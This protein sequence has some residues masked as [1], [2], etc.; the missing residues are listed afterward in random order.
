MQNVR[1]VRVVIKAVL[2]CAL[3]NLAFAYF[4]PPVGKLGIYNR[5]VVG[6][7]R[8]PNSPTE[9]DFPFVHSVSV[10]DN[11]D[12]LFASHVI[13]DG[14]KP[15][16]EYR[17]VFLGD[18]SVW[19]L[20]LPPR[21]TLTEQINRMHLTTCSGLHVRAYNLGF[22]VPSALR[23][24]LLIEKAQEYQPDMF[25]WLV[26]VNTFLDSSSSR[27]FLVANVGGVRTLVGR[28]HLDIDLSGI[29]PPSFWDNTFI[30]QRSALHKIALLQ[31]VGLAWAA[32]GVD[33]Y[34]TTSASAPI[35]P[36]NNSDYGQF[37]SPKFKDELLASLLLNVL[38]AGKEEAKGAA[39]LVVNE[40]IHVLPGSQNSVRYNAAFPRWAYDAYRQAWGGYVQDRGLRF[41]DLWDFL[42]DS[43]FFVN[44]SLHRS[45]AGE[46]MLADRL[47]PE[48]LQSACP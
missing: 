35:P 24:L 13:S 20:G 11:F 15:L 27:S 1:P 14:P 41:L 17:V 30:G 40:P 33:S 5:L 32:T 34:V 28:Y 12:A 26:T 36:L 16:D 42:A 31:L 47:A 29:R 18:S 39:L 21:A 22:P 46:Q 25:I 6:R 44:S 2:L 45:A 19:G 23:D 48:I 7:T 4:N 8:F 43:G 9:A 37:R 10:F 3:A 38:P